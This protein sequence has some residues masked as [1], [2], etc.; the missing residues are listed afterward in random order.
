MNGGDIFFRLSGGSSNDSVSAS[1]GGGMSFLYIDSGTME[2]VFPTISP[3]QLAAGITTYACIYVYN[4]HPTDT[5]Y[6]VQVYVSQDT[7]SPDI[8]IQLGADPAGP[9]G[10]ATTTAGPTVAPA[11]VAFAAHGSAG[12][13][14]A[15][16]A[17]G[18]GQGVA[19]WLKRIVSPSVVVLQVDNFTLSVTAEEI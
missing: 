7:D 15:L 17:L 13:A 14:L 8:A 12:A 5:A 11:G 10:V 2:N 6:S 18:P 19:L 4:D 16:G 9:G 3:T 1:L